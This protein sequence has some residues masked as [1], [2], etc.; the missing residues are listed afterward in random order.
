MSSPAED[1]LELARDRLWQFERAVCMGPKSLVDERIT[2]EYAYLL[3]LKSAWPPIIIDDLRYGHSLGVKPETWQLLVYYE[4][5]FNPPAQT[6]DICTTMLIRTRMLGAKP[7]S[8]EYEE[9]HA[10]ATSA[11]HDLHT[12]PALDAIEAFIKEVD[13]LEGRQPNSTIL[14]RIADAAAPG[15]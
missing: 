15:R 12:N 14:H 9:M 6:E 10:I 3:N 7:F 2:N 13:R 8:F 1:I 4:Y 11:G 5:R